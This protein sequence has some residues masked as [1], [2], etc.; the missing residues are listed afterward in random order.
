MCHKLTKESGLGEAWAPLVAVVGRI[1]FGFFTAVMLH[2]TLLLGGLQLAQSRNKNI[3]FSSKFTSCSLEA[4]PRSNNLGLWDACRCLSQT[5]TLMRMSA[6]GIAELKLLS[7]EVFVDCNAHCW[8]V[9][10]E[11]RNV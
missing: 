4:A 1:C 7:E 9:C 6:V 8:Q 10:G 5:V 3:R 11:V 2:L